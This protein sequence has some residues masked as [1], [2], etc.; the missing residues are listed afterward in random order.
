MSFKKFNKTKRG[1]LTALVLFT[2]MPTFHRCMDNNIEIEKINEEPTIIG[3]WRAVMFDI[4]NNDIWVDVTK[5]PLD[6]F[7]FTYQFLDDNIFN[8]S[9]YLGNG[10]GTYTH[11]GNTITIT[12]EHEY[13]YATCTILALSTDSLTLSIKMESSHD[14]RFIMVKDN[15]N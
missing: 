4:D 14:F 10:G 12:K 5:P 8:G 2:M 13:T 3:I 11:V 1:L 6:D 7:F 15:Q 9:G